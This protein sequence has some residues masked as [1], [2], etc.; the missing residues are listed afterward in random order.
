M[1]RVQLSPVPVLILQQRLEIAP[2]VEDVRYK[3]PV[4]DDDIGDN[5]GSLER[6]GAQS[7]QEIIARSSAARSVANLLAPIFDP[8][9]KIQRHL[10]TGT[11][12]DNEIED[13]SKIVSR[14]LPVFD[15]KPLDHLRGS[16]AGRRA[17][18]DVHE[19]ACLID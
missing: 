2:A 5:G 17:A 10:R 19:A 18:V 13:I 9:D 16:N 14:A 3:Y 11:T 6:D 15:L 12:I 8:Q 7:R 4:V 1:T